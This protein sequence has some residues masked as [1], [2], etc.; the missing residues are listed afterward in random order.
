MVGSNV[1]RFCT[2]QSQI[3]YSYPMVDAGICVDLKMSLTHLL[4][5]LSSDEWLK[6]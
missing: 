2:I 6:V 5:F 4:V 3:D 1:I